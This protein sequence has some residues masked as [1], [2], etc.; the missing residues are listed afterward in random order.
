MVHPPSRRHKPHPARL[1]DGD[2]Q[3]GPGQLR[4]DHRHLLTIASTGQFTAPAPFCAISDGSSVFVF[5]KSNQP[6]TSTAV[7]NWTFGDGALLVDRYSLSGGSLLQ[8]SEARYQRSR[9][10]DFPA[11]NKDCL[12][13]KDMNSKP[14]YEPTI[15]LGFVQNFDSFT[16]SLIPTAVASTSYWQIF[17]HS[18][19]GPIDAYSVLQ[20]Q[21]GLFDFAGSLSFACP[22]R[23]H[24]DF[25][26][27]PGTCGR[28]CNSTLTQ[29]GSSTT[30]TCP[31]GHT[32]TKPA[33][34]GA[35]PLPL[36]HACGLALAQVSTATSADACVALGGGV[37]ATLPGVQLPSNFTI[38]LW[39]RRSQASL[40]DS[41]LTQGGG[42][43][44][45]GFAATTGFQCTGGGAAALASTKTPDTYWHHYAVVYA[46]ATRTLYIDGLAVASDSNGSFSA[47]IGSQLLT[48]GTSTTNSTIY[49]DELRVWNIG[50]S[51]AE[52]QTGMQARRAGHEKGL[53]HYFRLNEGKGTTLMD[54]APDGI[55][56][57]GTLSAASGWA[58]PQAAA[59]TV[60]P[61]GGVRHNS[62]QTHG[63][64][65][66][67]LHGDRG[68][69]EPGRTTLLPAGDPAGRQQAA[70]VRRPPDA[71]PRR[72]LGR[73]QPR[74]PR[75]RD[76]GRRTPGRG[77][78]RRH[79]G[80]LDRAERRR[81]HPHLQRRAL[82]LAL[83]RPPR[84][85]A[86]C[87]VAA[88]A[89]QQHG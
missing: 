43:L 64:P 69:Q 55:W 39:C 78:G 76:R 49:V 30:Y 61:S 80:I 74:R 68:A 81:P 82:S 63:F 79:A 54:L 42:G 32:W 17:A 67:P 70:E 21:D 65:P 27:H 36:S 2:P 52:I 48:L 1:P 38:E 4:P 22:N 9:S 86:R 71:R 14:F 26:P 72:R 15:E 40:A 12:S 28:P 23:D 3:G 44:V 83:G 60:T 7:A 51:A 10:K 84:R 16:V 50:L 45:L 18:T 24:P 29:V 5:R 57:S 66:Q 31:N 34:W 25:Q 11:N 13:P 73:H 46:G 6:N 62:F 58:G 37:S 53:L 87:P 89:R 8:K 19:A 56:E 75:L 47:S 85:R 20:A 35:A 77:A 59:P 33:D 41:C 88:I